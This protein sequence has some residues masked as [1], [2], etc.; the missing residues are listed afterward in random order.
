[1]LVRIGD[2]LFAFDNEF[3]RFEFSRCLITYKAESNE[4]DFHFAT[5]V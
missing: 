3:P 1:M 4:F 5:T 2:G